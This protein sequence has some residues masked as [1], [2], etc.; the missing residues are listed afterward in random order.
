MNAELHK[1]QHIDHYHAASVRV[2]ATDPVAKF[3][4][5]VHGDGVVLQSV[6]DEE[7]HHEGMEHRDDDPVDEDE[8]AVLTRLHT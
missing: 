8:F 1:N 2:G 3:F 7:I 5:V 6:E 4:P